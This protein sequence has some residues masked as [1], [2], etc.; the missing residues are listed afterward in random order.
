MNL[1]NNSKKVF[2]EKRGQQV[3]VSSDEEA[4]EKLPRDVFVMM[5]ICDTG[6]LSYQTVEDLEDPATLL[7]L[8][9]AL[10]GSISKITEADQEF[11]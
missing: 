10:I 8:G 7:H 6:T 5:F 2:G 3:E 1:W 11:G 9:F 4:S